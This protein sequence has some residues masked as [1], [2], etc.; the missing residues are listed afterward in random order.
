[1]FCG[2]VYYQDLKQKVDNKIYVTGIFIYVLFFYFIFINFLKGKQITVDEYSGQAKAGRKTG[3]SIKC[4]N[5]EVNC[6]D[7]HGVDGVSRDI[8]S[9]DS[10]MT[11]KCKSCLMYSEDNSKVCVFCNKEKEEIKSSYSFKLLTNELLC[12][13]ISLTSQNVSE[14]NNNEDIEIE[15]NI[16]NEEEEIDDEEE[17]EKEYSSKKQK[18]F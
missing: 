10:K 11:M 17:Y 18:I 9:A 8:F 1:M 5:M 2:L 6:F 16:D 7:A 4:G 13:N 15:Y 14:I 3:G 12:M